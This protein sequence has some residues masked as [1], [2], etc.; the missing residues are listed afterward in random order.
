MMGIVD[1]LLLLSKVRSMDSVLMDPLNMSEHIDSVLTRFD[2]DEPGDKVKII[3][4]EKWPVVLGY[5]PWVEE[6]WANYISNAIKYGGQ[7]PVVELGVD[8]HGS[9][10]R[11]W[12][13]DNGEGLSQTEQDSLF[14]DFSRLRRHA[15]GHEGHGLGLSIVRRIAS[16][17]GGQVG[18]ESDGKNGCTFFFTLKGN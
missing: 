12:V 17:L 14:Q 6:I 11:F 13:K 2:L 4:P 1:A 8:K 3:R 7:D 18:V 15:S 16:K 10:Y 9:F 5:G